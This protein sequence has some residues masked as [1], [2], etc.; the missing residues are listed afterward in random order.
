MGSFHSDA[1]LSVSAN[2]EAEHDLTLL[3]DLRGPGRTRRMRNPRGDDPRGAEEAVGDVGQVHRA[4]DALAQA[5]PAPVYLGHDRLGVGPARDGIAVAAI[6][7]QELVVGPERR[8]RPHDRRLGA[9][10]E[11]RVAADHARVIEERALHALLE[12][13]DAQHLLVDPDEPIAVERLDSIRR[14]H[15]ELL[16]CPNCE[17]VVS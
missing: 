10:G 13:P 1:M 9:V 16:S 2:E 17:A 4:P 12:L 3:A 15:A 11:V 14:A 8:D 7:R 5:V 6:G